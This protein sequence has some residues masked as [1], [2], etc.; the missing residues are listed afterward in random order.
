M[1]FLTDILNG[2]LPLTNEQKAQF[3][4]VAAAV[5]NAVGEAEKLD[6]QNINRVSERAYDV[7]TRA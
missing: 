5:L 7:H 6:A 3:K 2:N 1:P 4:P